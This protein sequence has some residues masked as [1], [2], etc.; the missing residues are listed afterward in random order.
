MKTF[1]DLAIAIDAKS[2][3]TRGHTEGVFRYAIR[4]AEALNMTEE[5]KKSLQL[6]SLLHNVGMVSV[7]DTLLNKPGPL[8]VEEKKIIKA[9]PGLAELLVKESGQLSAVLF[10]S[11]A[12]S[13]AT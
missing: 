9:H 13:L 5:D 7:P 4:L 3:Y 12:R 1:W 10:H 2:P 11:G 8:S 6:A